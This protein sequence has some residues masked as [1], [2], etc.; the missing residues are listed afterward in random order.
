MKKIILYLFLGVITFNVAGQ[1]LDKSYKTL[2]L[3]LAGGNGFSPALSYTKMFGIGKSN[4]FKIGYG[5]RL[6]SFFGSDVQ[7][8]T[9]PAKLTSGSASFVALFSDDIVANID[10][11]KLK[12]VQSNALN[13]SINLQYALT[14]KLEVGFN[15]DAL[16]VTFGGNQSGDIISLKN[17]RKFS[18]GSTQS[19]ASPSG[20]NLLLVS[21]SD[22]G[23]LNSELYARYWVSDKIGIRAGL[24]FQFVEY[25]SDKKVNVN[26]DE[27]NRWRYKSLLPLVAVSYKF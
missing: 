2:D 7:F 16:G 8:R 14:Q 19:S 5:I 25:M 13:I 24:S 21:D 26:A 17:K 23:S 6:T 1:G 22:I 9:A 18:D 4:R 27:N 20:L 11:F 15:I 10:T 12:S 3:A